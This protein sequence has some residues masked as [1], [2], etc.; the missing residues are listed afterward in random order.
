[1]FIICIMQS[2]IDITV[3]ASDQLEYRSGCT[4]EVH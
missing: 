3:V 2:D 1:M 4:V